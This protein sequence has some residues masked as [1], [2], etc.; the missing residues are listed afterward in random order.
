MASYQVMLDRTEA[1]K[2][3][4]LRA[5]YG[6]ARCLD[7]LQRAEKAFDRYMNVVYKYFENRERNTPECDVWFTR[8]AFNAAEI[9]ELEK[10]WRA[11][12]NIYQ[13][14]VDA[15][16]TAAA[17]AQLRIQKIKTEQWLFFY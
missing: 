16:V 7:K 4:R 10:S 3:L 14:I 11:A 8:A 1:Q 15:G 12:A 2:E 13:R 5:E 17:D 6:I 9:K